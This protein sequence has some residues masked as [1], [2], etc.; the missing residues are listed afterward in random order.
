MLNYIE[1]KYNTMLIKNNHMFKVNLILLKLNIWLQ[2]DEKN[3]ILLFYTV[4]NNNN[5]NNEFHFFSFFATAASSE[6]PSTSRSNAT[7]A[8]IH[9]RGLS[10]VFNYPVKI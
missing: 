6:T 5:K 3:Y 10:L 8:K 9:L 4:Y 7:P 2:K 1:E